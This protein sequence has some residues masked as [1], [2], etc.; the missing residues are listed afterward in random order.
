MELVRLANERASERASQT[1]F[2]DRHS[3]MK[4]EDIIIVRSEEADDVGYKIR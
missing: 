2:R 1:N 3:V 4:A